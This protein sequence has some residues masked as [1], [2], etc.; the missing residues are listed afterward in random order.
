[1]IFVL[2]RPHSYPSNCNLAITVAQNCLKIS[3]NQVF[4]QATIIDFPK[5]IKL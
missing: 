2:A 3:I 4:W 1:M 5:Q